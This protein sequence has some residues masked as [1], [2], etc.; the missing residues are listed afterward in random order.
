MDLVEKKA[1][2]GKL[3][4]VGGPEEAVDQR[5]ADVIDLTEL[6]K[7]SLAA[8]PGKRAASEDDE[9]EA[10]ASTRKPASKSKPAAKSSTRTRKA[11]SDEPRK[12]SSRKKA[13]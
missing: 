13:G 2:E 5:S 3:E 8:K 11:A 4:A 1:R 9:P 7:R 6:L 12:G 10:A